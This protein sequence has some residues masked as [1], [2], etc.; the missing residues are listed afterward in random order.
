MDSPSILDDEPGGHVDPGASRKFPGDGFQEALPVESGLE[1]K[2]IIVEK[3]FEKRSPF[4]NV[5]QKFLAW[6]GNMPEKGDGGEGAGGE[7][8]ELLR[9]EGE[10]VVVDPQDPDLVP[11]GDPCD[12][13]GEETIDRLVTQK[14][15]R[16][17]SDSTGLLMKERPKEIVRKSLV[18]LLPVGVFNREAEQGVGSGIPGNGN[19]EG[20]GTGRALQGN[21]VSSRL[22]EESV[23]GLADAAC[24]I[25]ELWRVALRRGPLCGRLDDDRFPVGCDQ[26]LS[27][28]VKTPEAFGDRQGV[29][30]SGRFS[31]RECRVFLD[32]LGWGQ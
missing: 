17:R 21:P 28:P 10:L 26:K 4:R 9:D 13:V 1:A 7:G 14:V 6:P 3:A 15:S 2:K 30:C 8:P 20:R 24:R 22:K 27:G 16:A 12:V 5:S 32:R 11:M 23:K 31:W 25:A 29:P 19:V 18:F